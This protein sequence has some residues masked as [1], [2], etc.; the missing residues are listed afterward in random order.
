MTDR[1][2]VSGL[3]RYIMGQSMGGA[4]ALKVHLKE[5][6]TWDGVILVAP[7]CKVST[8]LCVAV[9]VTDFIIIIFMSLSYYEFSSFRAL[10]CFIHRIPKSSEE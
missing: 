3:P 7:M 5:P 9:D 8:F 4:I 1:P 2:E 6:N 10:N